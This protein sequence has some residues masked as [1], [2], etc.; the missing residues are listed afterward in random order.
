MP[1]RQIRRTIPEL[2]LLSDLINRTTTSQLGTTPTDDRGYEQWMDDYSSSQAAASP[3]L[4]NLAAREMS[5]LRQSSDPGI[6]RQAERD[7]IRRAVGLTRGSRWDPRNYVDVDEFGHEQSWDVH[8]TTDPRM[9]PEGYNDALR[10]IEQQVLEEKARRAAP[11]LLKLAQPVSRRDFFRTMLTPAKKAAINATPLGAIS[12][13]V[14]SES[15]L[16][17]KV[18][19]AFVS[20]FGRPPA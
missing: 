20:R 13:A 11:L 9:D 2:E 12:N 17:M 14:S 4:R 16:L 10:S 7:R 18:I 6:G 8:S 19:K 15:P 3:L 1:P 5:L